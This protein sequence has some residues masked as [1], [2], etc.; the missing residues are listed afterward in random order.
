MT[1][2]EGKLIR[3]LEDKISHNQILLRLVSKLAG[4]VQELENDLA[5]SYD[6]HRRYAAG[7]PVELQEERKHNL[8]MAYNRLGQLKP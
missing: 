8:V 7:L 3:E 5:E 4:R 2:R 6:Y 1:K